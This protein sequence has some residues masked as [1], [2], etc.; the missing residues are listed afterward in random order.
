MSKASDL[1]DLLLKEIGGNSPAP[2]VTHFL[3]TGSP[4]LNEKMSGKRDGGLPYGRLVECYGPSSCGKT[5]WA[6]KM[7]AKAQQL[8]GIAGFVDWE[9]SFSV[10]LAKS[11]FD[12]ND[13]RP[14]W[15]Y[16]KPRTWEEGNTTALKAVR[17]I[18]A[19]GL[20]DKDA[21]ILFVFDSI[22]SAIPS[23]SLI[24][25][26]A[27]AGQVKDMSELNMNDTTALARVTSTTLKIMAQVAEECNAIFL[28]LN[29]IRTKPGVSFGDPTTTPGGAAMEYYSTVRLSLAREKIS[30]EVAGADGKKKKE[31][32]GQDIRFHVTKSKLTKPFQTARMRMTF[33]AAG[34]AHFDYA[35]SNIQFL[36]DI[37]KLV[38][39]GNYI[40][41]TDG[42]KYGHEQLARHLTDNGLVDELAK[43]SLS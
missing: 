37:G 40:E 15:I 25:K 21:P 20:I 38:K 14:H 2:A 30:K 41:W 22:A 17:A 11:G 26:G 24:D 10:E 13:T 32:M 18:R 27:N 7:L 29:Q 4:E 36:L 3:D 8:G 43:L 9:R 31:F 23:S 6:T 42:K 33:D 28:Y 35:F 5:A 19:S 12:L 39:T 16:I 1:A 34:V